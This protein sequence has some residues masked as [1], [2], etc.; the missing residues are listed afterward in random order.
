MSEA[1]IGKGRMSRAIWSL[2]KP[3][4]ETSISETEA[5]IEPM[6]K[7]DTHGDVGG[8]RSEESLSAEMSNAKK[9]RAQRD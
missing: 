5:R 3:I 6:Q 7:R 8:S 2:E 1:A 9:R 4:L